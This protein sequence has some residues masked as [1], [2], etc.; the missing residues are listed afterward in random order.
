MAVGGDGVIS[1]LANLLPD[2]FSSMIQL[3]RQNDFRAAAKVHQLLSPFYHL[4]S[5]EGN[6]SSIKAGLSV[7][8]LIKPSVRPPLAAAT[9]LLEA[10]F[11]LALKDLET[12]Q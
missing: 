5:A 8:G 3:A 11:R 10:Q 6:P 9:K 1:V 4:S 7:S 12:S 2:H